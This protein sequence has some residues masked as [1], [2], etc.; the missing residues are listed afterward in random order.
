MVKKAVA[1]KEETLPSYIKQGQ[2]RGNENVTQ[3]D[4]QLPRIDVLQALSPQINK[5]KDEYIEGAEAGMLF[6]TL[7]GELYEDGI[8]ICP[9]SFVKRHLVWVDRKKDSEGGLRGVFDTAEEA[10]TFIEAQDDEDKLEVVPTSEH[11][12]LLE[13][14]SE[15]ILSMAKSKTKVSRK[16]N[17]LV[18]LNGGDR[19][20]R[21]YVVTTVDDKGPKGEFQNISISSSG[22]PT[23]EVYLKAEKLYEAIEAG[24]RQAG[25]NYEGE[26]GNGDT[27]SEG[28]AQ[29]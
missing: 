3:D 5:K 16:F 18:R 1:K 25:G 22:F 29:Y 11:L 27:T 12:V 24:A 8:T 17:S 2:N 21:S 6:N 23:E 7:T 19:F 9:I 26:T 15:V 14:G 10:E 20:S 28:D 13:D 4:L